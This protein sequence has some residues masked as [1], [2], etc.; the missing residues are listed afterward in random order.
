LEHSA[1]EIIPAALGRYGNLSALSAT[2]FRI[3][4]VGLNFEFLDLI[5]RGFVDVREHVVRRVVR[6][7]QREVIAALVGSR[8]AD[9]ATESQAGTGLRR[10]NSRRDVGELLE[11]AA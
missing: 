11:V 6:A 8:D 1:M 5:D 2:A 9:A 4:R 3:V 10:G 7:I